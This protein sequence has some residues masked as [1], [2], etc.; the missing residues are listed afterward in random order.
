[1]EELRPEGY[2]VLGLHYDAEPVE[3]LTND[4][5]QKVGEV[6]NKWYKEYRSLGLSHDQAVLAAT[7]ATTAELTRTGLPVPHSVTGGAAQLQKDILTRIGAC[8]HEKLVLTGYSQGAWVVRLA[9]SNL[10]NDPNWP[11]ISESI[12][13]IG[14]LAEP[15]PQFFKPDTFPAELEG[16]THRVCAAGDSV[17]GNPL[18]ALIPL[19]PCGNPIFG[20]KATP[21]CP[22]LRYREDKTVLGTGAEEIANWLK[23]RPGLPSGP[24]EFPPGFGL[25]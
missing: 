14:L 8:P 13:A 12:S 2:L 17:C 9:L 21:A 11:A 3:K 4:S 18:G 20:T 5:M 15:N 6:Y 7:S 23:L 24:L 22:H 1:M 10:K 19:N 25:Q 16:K